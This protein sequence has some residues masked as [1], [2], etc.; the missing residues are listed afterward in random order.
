MHPQKPLQIATPANSRQKDL[1]EGFEKGHVSAPSATPPGAPERLERALER[2]AKKKSTKPLTAKAAE[3][4][5][6]DPE[7]EENFLPR[8]LKTESDCTREIA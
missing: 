8:S 4:R 6:R 7:T 2:A 3:T 1:A 5:Y